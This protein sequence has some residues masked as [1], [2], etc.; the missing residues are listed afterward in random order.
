MEEFLEE[1]TEEGLGVVAA[2][3]DRL[4]SAADQAAEGAREGYN[5]LRQGYAEAE[6]VIQERPG[7]TVAVAFGLGLL[8]GLGVAL[9]LRD[10]NQEYRFSRGRNA[11]EHLGCQIRDALAGIIPDSLTKSGGG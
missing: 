1:L 5:A 11:A 9:L 2:A 7:Q 6:R 4:S 3:R 10:R 8:S